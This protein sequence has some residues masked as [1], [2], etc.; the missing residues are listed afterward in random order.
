MNRHVLTPFIGSVCLLALL[1]SVIACSRSGDSG[2]K[3][4]PQ[5]SPTSGST[6]PQKPV[7]VKLAC[8][9]A[10]V[11]SLSRD[12][13]PYRVL[14]AGGDGNLKLLAESGGN[15]TRLWG[16]DGN[17]GR[18]LDEAYKTGLTVAVGIWL[19]H[20]Q[21]GFDYANKER[22]K[23][24]YDQVIAAVKQY[25]DHPAV[26]VWGLGNEMEGYETGANPDLWKHVE[27]LAK[28][29]K[30][31]DPNHPTMSVVAE[32]TPDK[33]K[34]IHEHCPSLDI[35]GINSYGGCPTIPER[36]RQHGGTKPYI[37]TEFGPVG[38]WE[39]PKNN[40]DAIEEPT[41]V[42]K[43]EMYREAYRKLAADKELCLGTYAFLWGNKQ[44]GTATWF[45]L[46]LPSG[47]K[48]NAVDMLIE[49]WT[50]KPPANRCPEVTSLK[51][52]GKNEILPGE[53]VQLELAASD[54]E[55]DQLQVNWTVMQE[56]DR[57]VTGGDPQATPP[58]FTDAVQAASATGCTV[59]LPKTPGMYRVYVEVLD[60]KGQASTANVPIR[61]SEPT[62]EAGPAVAL[63]YTIYA[64]A[65]QP[66]E[67]S[68]SGWMGDTSAVV[69]TPESKDQ[70]HGGETC[71]KCEY[72][73]A[74]GWAGVVWQNP[75]GDWGE[76]PGGKNFS[77]AKRLAF[78][79]RGAEG[80]EKL[81][82]GFGLLGREKAYF[83]TT[84]KEQEFTLTKEWQRFEI[85]LSEQNLQRIKSPFFWVHAA[86][87]KPATF[88]FDD[89]VVE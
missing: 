35:I 50:G 22:V 33:V 10:G 26:L 25:K 51:L 31:I 67:F 68:P 46:L 54:P 53:K 13:K 21:K 24:Q 72:K 81:K 5:A 47:E 42:R 12:G 78:W 87:G 84:K 70:P 77:G 64:E 29:I 88:Y 52:I 3:T 40:L 80:G 71:L 32:L 89:V 39:V 74:A 55:G 9:E 8:S 28:A 76:K 66:S 34:A 7:P 65:G 14:G 4:N 11:W 85:D 17:T 41:S 15:S 20:S 38:T 60:G 30:E 59:E 2:G 27:S 18:R 44:E 73:A 1:A 16:V 56:A 61:V 69:M 83:D 58:T 23:Q 75:E 49:E 63:P 36:Y 79:A 19:E 57:Y 45:G 86:A 48:T 37:V 62:I 82:V 6:V 43:A